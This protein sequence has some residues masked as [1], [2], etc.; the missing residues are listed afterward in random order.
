MIKS[1]KWKTNCNDM[2]KYTYFCALKQFRFIFENECT[3]Y[4]VKYPICCEFIPFIFICYRVVVLEK[5]H[6]IC[7]LLHYEMI[8]FQR[9]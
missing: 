1:D 6:V 7:V 8:F 3:F 4:A 2:C 5:V 9:P